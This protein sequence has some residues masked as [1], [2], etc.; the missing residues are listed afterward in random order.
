MKR[1]PY[2]IL[3]IS[4]LSSG[5]E[6]KRAYRRMSKLYNPEENPEM[7]KNEDK[8]KIFKEAYNILSDKERRR[9]YDGSPYFSFKKVRVSSTARLSSDDLSNNKMKFKKSDSL[10]DRIK[11]FFNTHRRVEK[12][13]NYDP[14][15]ADMHFSLGISLCDKPKFIEQSIEEFKKAIE[16]DPF[17]LECLYNI[18]I[19]YYKT[20]QFDESIIYF[21]KIL[22]IDKTYKSALSM[23]FLLDDNI[24]S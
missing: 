2:K 23:V 4:P 19:A 8:I 17:H 24:Y 15:A 21:K 16:Y 11:S 9:E 3:G 13:S 22:A 10:L 18:G 5:E 6:I 20:G 1:D 12:L 7:K 14:K